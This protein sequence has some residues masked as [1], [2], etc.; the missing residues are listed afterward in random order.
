[1]TQDQQSPS[2]P[3][4]TIRVVPAE[5]IL[6][7]AC[8][9]LLPDRPG[10]PGWMPL[11]VAR[12]ASSGAVLGAAKGMPVPGEGGSV[13]LRVAIHVPAPYRRRGVG[14]AI[15]EH[16]A[17]ET[18]RRRAMALNGMPEPEDREGAIPFLV[19]CGFREVDRMTTFEARVERMA[20]WLRERR[21]WL[22]ER[23]EIPA[24]ARIVPLREAPIERVAALHAETIGGQ[25]ARLEAWFRDLA[26][27]PEV[28]DT[29]VLL[30][31]GAVHGFHYCDSEGDTSTT[32]GLA[33]TA[34]LRGGESGSGWAALLL[35]ADRV[36]EAV[37]RGV[38]RSRFSCLSHV[39][40]TLRLAR[41]FDATTVDV[42]EL[43]RRDLSAPAPPADAR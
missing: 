9:M 1:M 26:H 29:V 12:D 11:V 8:S 13:Q 6:R 42:R 37:R 35:L 22:E 31:D 34:E 43:L 21:R 32:H 4:V 28:C 24:T 39:R 3:P 5:G 10:V 16:L 14:R 36:D 2:R 41:I 27:G 18:R 20:E 15:V 17:E 25:P 23:D 19:A 30:V 33:V 7:R 38:T 40:P